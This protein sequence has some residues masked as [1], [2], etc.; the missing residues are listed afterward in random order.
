[1]KRA[2]DFNV[3]HYKTWFGD[4]NQYKKKTTLMKNHFRKVI[5]SGA[6][7][8]INKEKNGMKGYIGGNGLMEMTIAFHYNKPI[9]I[10]NDISD[11]SPIAE[12]I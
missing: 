6:I 2:N 4:K 11:D 8:M 5:E 10:Y 3:S 7:L 9:F 1:M 12:E